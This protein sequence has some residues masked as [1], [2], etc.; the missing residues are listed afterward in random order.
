MSIGPDIKEVLQELG[1]PLTIYKVDGTTITGE[2]LD[3]ESYYDSSTEFRRQFCY[4]GD[5]QYDSAVAEGDII[6]FDSKFFLMLTIRKEM[7]EN[8]TV[9]Y[10]NFF[11]E[12]N[13]IG[14]LSKQVKTR[15]PAS[16]SEDIVW[17]AS[18]DSIHALHFEN[19]PSFEEE[20]GM[21]FVNNQLT[22]YIQNYTDVIIGDRWYP[23]V[24][25]LTVYYR[26]AAVLQN[27]YRNIHVC[28]LED[29]SRE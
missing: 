3:Y 27:T 9:D 12:C 29:D 21:D 5:F 25:D 8:S 18:H 20:T 15:D 26:I 4:S 23:D 1:S 7:F 13:S 10:Q 19:S 17:T 16:Y 22:V 2:Y 28:K 14:R 11:V 24:T 6:S